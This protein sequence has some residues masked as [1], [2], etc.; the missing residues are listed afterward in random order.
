VLDQRRREQRGRR[1]R[2][3]DRSVTSR[4][5][6]VELVAKAI[7]SASGAA[8]P[9]HAPWQLVLADNQLSI[10]LAARLLVG[11]PRLDQISSPCGSRLPS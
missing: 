8:T 9:G 4:Q 6:A 7:R 10:A 5:P 11:E 3:I 1:Q 2:A